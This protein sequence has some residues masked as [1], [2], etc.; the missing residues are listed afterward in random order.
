MNWGFIPTPLL[1]L[2]SVQQVRT[3]VEEALL[4]TRRSDSPPCLRLAASDANSSSFFKVKFDEPY[5]M[6]RDWKNI[7]AML[8]CGESAK[9]AKSK[10]ARPEAQLFDGYLKG[11]GIIGTR[12]LFLRWSET[13]EGGSDKKVE[14]AG[15]VAAVS[16]K[17]FGRTIIIP[18][19]VPGL[20]VPTDDEADIV[21]EMDVR[22]DLE[23]AL[24]HQL[25]HPDTEHV[26]AALAKACRHR[27]ERTDT[28]TPQQQRKPSAPPRYFSVLAEMDL[29]DALD[30]RIAARSEDD[31][32]RKFWDVLRARSGFVRRPHVTI[33]HSKQ[34]PDCVDLWER[35]AALYGLPAP[36]LLSASLGHVVANGR[37][38]AATV[39]DLRVDDPEAD[40]A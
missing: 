25:P 6:Y 2:P 27:P 8:T 39:E 37:I 12:E 33:V 38:M 21:I 18:I 11:H 22:E 23:H 35:C 28:Q 10:M 26:G 24:S 17:K 36:P 31:T 30:A 5:L 16:D 40:K 29:V 20:E 7:K 4:C 13:G 3:F 15:A 9:L 14:N 32:V 1:E 34:L 19:T